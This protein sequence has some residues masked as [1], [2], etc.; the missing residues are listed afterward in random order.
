MRR[1]YPGTPPRAPPRPAGPLGDGGGGRRRGWDRR[2][3][4][5]VP[6]DRLAP[7]AVP[8]VAVGP[9]GRLRG[10]ARGHAGPVEPRIPV[11]PARVPPNDARL[12]RVPGRHAGRRRRPHPRRPPRKLPPRSLRRRRHQ[13]RRGHEQRPRD[14][15]RGRQPARRLRGDAQDVEARPGRRDGNLRVDE[16]DGASGVGRPRRSR[17]RVA[18]RGKFGE[19][20]GTRTR[21]VRTRLRREP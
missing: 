13:P 11:H 14:V 6:R 15:R 18:R 8:G 9:R 2:R 12:P 17:R 20:P 10:V 3:A 4:R 7:F 19:P 5:N 1:V 16:G 21:D